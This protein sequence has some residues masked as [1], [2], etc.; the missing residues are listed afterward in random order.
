MLMNMQLL[1]CH[2]SE[3]CVDRF[4]LALLSCV[5]QSLLIHCLQIIIAGT[6]FISCS[7]TYTRLETSG[8]NTVQ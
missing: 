6:L 3:I 5:D 7:G 2:A 4:Q 1:S 8:E